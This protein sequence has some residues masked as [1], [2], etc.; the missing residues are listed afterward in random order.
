MGVTVY[1][2]RCGREWRK[3]C[4][5]KP[6]TYDE[7]ACGRTAQRIF[8]APSAPVVYEVRDRYRGV[9]MR[10]DLMRQ[11]RDRSR[12][13]TLRYHVDEIIDRVGPEIAQ[14]AGY[15]NS[16]GSKKRRIDEK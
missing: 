13:H 15:L 11:T 9:T 3:I 4:R 5:G 6:R 2:C 7:C 8:S 1:T 12:A 14:R 16:D 10:Q